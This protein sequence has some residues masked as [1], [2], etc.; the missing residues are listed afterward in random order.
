MSG[1]NCNLLSEAQGEGR[2]HVGSQ[3]P[4]LPILSPEVF[5]YCFLYSAV[6]FALCRA[7]LVSAEFD[8]SPCNA[9][10]SAVWRSWA[11][12]GKTPFLD[13]E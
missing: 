11:K 1:H 5:L 6:F 10:L 12:M 4:D 3:P 2:I 9:A 7:E 8:L 13:Y